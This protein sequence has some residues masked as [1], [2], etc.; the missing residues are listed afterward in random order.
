[1]PHLSTPLAPPE[2]QVLYQLWVDE[3]HPK[4]GK[5]AMPIGP[6]MSKPM[7]G[8]LM[9]AINTAIIDG[10]E[11][12]WRNPRLEPVVTER[13]IDSPFTREDRQNELVGGYRSTSLLTH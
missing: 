12:Q 5:R 2:D 9:Q 11:K 7:F 13:I 1:M 3:D 6:K 10:T 4:W 8:P